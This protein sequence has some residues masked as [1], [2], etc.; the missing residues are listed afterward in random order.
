MFGIVQ[1][2]LEQSKNRVTLG[3]LSLKRSLLVRERRILYVRRRDVKLRKWI[4]LQML[5]RMGRDVLDKLS[6]GAVGIL[7][8]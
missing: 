3:G 4:G 2:R 1:V 7:R 5:G 6:N 8:L